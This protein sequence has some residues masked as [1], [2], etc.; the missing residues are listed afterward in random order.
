[1]D[2]ELISR[3][4]NKR[5]AL[6]WGIFWN[7]AATF[8]INPK[9][10][11]TGEG[12]VSQA[13]TLPPRTATDCVVQLDDLFSEVYDLYWKPAVEKEL[14][15]LNKAQNIGGDWSGG[16]AV[17]A[18]PAGRVDLVEHLQHAL[19]RWVARLPDD[20][21]E[22]FVKEFLKLG[23]GV[24]KS[25]VAGDSE[26]R[27]QERLALMERVKSQRLLSPPDPWHKDAFDHIPIGAPANRQ[28]AARENAPAWESQIAKNKLTPEA[29]GI[30][31]GDMAA[32]LEDLLEQL[33]KATAKAGS[34]TALAEFLRKTTGRKVPL[35]NV[36]R[37][38]A[39]KRVPEAE[40][41]LQMQ[42][43]LKRP[44]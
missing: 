26:S 41:V 35:A 3:V 36:S 22:V 32:K 17:F 33:R 18:T 27:Q 9:W 30:T 28:E 15:A 39:G 34:K 14:E 42:A 44:T 38:L 1:M 12:I 11:A 29:T 25:L 31:S 2:S 4:E 16:R 19:F 24:A 13:V 8:P 7:I 20:R 21:L 23:D 5:V 37:W 6:Q 10:L 40:I 43:W